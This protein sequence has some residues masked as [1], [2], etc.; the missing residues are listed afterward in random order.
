MGEKETYSVK[1]GGLMRCCLQSLDDEMVERQRLDQ[2]LMTNERTIAC[3]YCQTEMICDG[4]YWQWNNRPPVAE[5]GKE[6]G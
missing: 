4:G 5:E 2:P 1:Q 6:K 3:R